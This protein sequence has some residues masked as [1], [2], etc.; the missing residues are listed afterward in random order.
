[1]F[2]Q[3]GRNVVDKAII[4]LRMRIIVWRRIEDHIRVLVIARARSRMNGESAVERHSN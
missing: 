4:T 2:N 3:K 1:M